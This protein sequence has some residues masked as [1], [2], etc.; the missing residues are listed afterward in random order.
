MH[1]RNNYQENL[2]QKNNAK[3]AVSL[4]KES[5]GMKEENEEKRGYLKLYLSVTSPDFKL[6]V[7]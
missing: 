4:V 6:P 1:T 7:L 2:K 5:G 3:H